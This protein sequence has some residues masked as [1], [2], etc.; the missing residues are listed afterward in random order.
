MTA[1]FPHEKPILLVL[2]ASETAAEGIL[3]FL[4]RTEVRHHV[5]PPLWFLD[6]SGV[7]LPAA[8]PDVASVT[9]ETLPRVLK[10]AER[11]S[12]AEVLRA[13]GLRVWREADEQVRHY[14]L[15][16][17]TLQTFAAIFK[18]APAAKDREP[19]PEF[20][21]DR[22]HEHRFEVEYRLAREPQPAEAPAPGEEGSIVF[23]PFDP[24]N[25]A[26][27]RDAGLPEGAG[28]VLEVFAYAWQR[29]RH[30]ALCESLARA[31]GWRS[32]DLA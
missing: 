20:W 16:R 12:T 19:P 6:G 30:V 27:R 22:I 17:T 1:P 24:P 28:V 13:H 32:V 11:L 8:I 23:Y 29:E 14:Y 2:S 18:V 26:A 15:K 5:F 31:Q 9:T 7:D 25:A 3:A 21:E 4:A 10:S